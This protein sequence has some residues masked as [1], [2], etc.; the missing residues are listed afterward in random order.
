MLSEGKLAM[1]LLSDVRVIGGN[2][3]ALDLKGFTVLP[4]SLGTNLLWHEFCVI[5][6]LPLELLIGADILAPH[7]CSLHYLKDDKKRLHFGVTAY[8][9]CNRFRNDPKAGSAAQLRFVDYDPRQKRKRLEV[10]YHSVATLPEAVCSD[11]DEKHSVSVEK[12]DETYGYLER[13]SLD[14]ISSTADPAEA[15]TPYGTASQCTEVT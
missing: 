8:A 11:S 14:R 9:R 5:L 3:E 2:G 7:L 1:R 4:V 12:V 13:R 6:N 15:P 10:G